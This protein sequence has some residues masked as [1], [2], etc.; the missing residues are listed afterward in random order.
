[1]EQSSGGY[2]G[3]WQSEKTAVLHAQQVQKNAEAIMRQNRME[4]RNEK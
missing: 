4:G 3:Y 2:A 1:M